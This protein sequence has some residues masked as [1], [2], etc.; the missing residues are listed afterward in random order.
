MMQEDMEKLILQKGRSK[1]DEK[2]KKK[3]KRK[4]SSSSGSS[5]SSKS[6]SSSGGRK[7]K[8]RK[9]ARWR[10]AK[11]S[12]KTITAED[13]RNLETMRFKRRADLIQ[14]SV[15]QPGALAA[16]FLTAI[17]MALNDGPP[18]SS[19]DLCRVD[20]SRWAKDHSTL[21]EVRDLR[22]IQTLM[23]VMQRLNEDQVPQAMDVL[24]QRVKAILSAK[25]AKGTWEKAQLIELLSAGMGVLPQSEITLTGL[26]STS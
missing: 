14:L 16:Q 21:K 24:A 20:V 2:D 13:V 5:R 3:K 25:H 6:S 19:R 11:A 15:E 12:K 9:H 7:R 22:E 26:G 4:D 17:K 18:A 1:K 23:L 8:T 10:P